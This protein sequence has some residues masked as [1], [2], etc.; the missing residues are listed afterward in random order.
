[1]NFNETA[2]HDDSDDEEKLT[3][4]RLISRTFKP[5]GGSSE[6]VKGDKIKVIKGDL[7]GM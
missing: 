6:I 7:I 1:M 2:N 4:E 3:A 5:D